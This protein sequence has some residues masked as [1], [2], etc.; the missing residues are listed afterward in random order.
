MGVAIMD[1]PGGYRLQHADIQ[2]NFSSN[3][4][5]LAIFGDM[6]CAGCHPFTTFNQSELD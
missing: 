4:M 6:H 2:K 3:I 5:T 1:R